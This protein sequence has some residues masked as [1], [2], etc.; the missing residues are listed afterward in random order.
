MGGCDGLKGSALVRLWSRFYLAKAPRRRRAFLPEAVIGTE[1][2]LVVE[3]ESNPSPQKY[4]VATVILR[5]FGDLLLLVT[6]VRLSDVGRA[7]MVA[8]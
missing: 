6:V 2:G 4:G 8:G 7:V 5:A 1:N 3:F